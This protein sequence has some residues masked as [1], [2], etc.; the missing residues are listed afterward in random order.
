[1]EKAKIPR[2]ASVLLAAI[3]C[4]L[5]ACATTLDPAPERSLEQGRALYAGKCQGCHRLRQPSKIDP[6][7]W[8]TILDKMAVKAKLTPEQKAQVDAYVQAVSPR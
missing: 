8:P 3:A 6:Q 2:V 5:A 1:M 7:K 4:S